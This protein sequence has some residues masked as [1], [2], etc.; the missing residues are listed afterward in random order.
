[1][2][3]QHSAD[4]GTGEIQYNKFSFAN[5]STPLA[6]TVLASWRSD[7]APVFTATEADDRCGQRGASFQDVDANG[8][9]PSI[10]SPG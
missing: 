8:V 10:G 3:A 2:V 5:P 6:T 7:A 1:M 4:N 9:T